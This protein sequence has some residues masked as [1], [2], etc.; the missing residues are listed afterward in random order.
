MLG[1]F[2]V[3]D[4]MAYLT[5]KQ[6]AKQKRTTNLVQSALG[7]PAAPLMVIPCQALQTLH[8]PT[9]HLMS[10]MLWNWR[11]WHDKLS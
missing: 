2:Q 11:C 9:H 4:S 8:F 10:D 1:V 7:S 3:E 6:K 5:K